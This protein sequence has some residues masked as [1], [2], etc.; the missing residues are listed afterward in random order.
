MHATYDFVGMTICKLCHML[1]SRGAQAP[2]SL[3]TRSF[4][5]TLLKRNTNMEWYFIGR[6]I[7]LQR[8][9]V[10][11]WE[12]TRNNITGSWVGSCI[13]W[14][15]L[16]DLTDVWH[17]LRPCHALEITS[18][19]SCSHYCNRHQV[20]SPTR[21]WFR[22]QSHRCK[23]RVHFVRFCAEQAKDILYSWWERRLLPC[24]HGTKKMGLCSN[25]VFAQKTQRKIEKV[26]V[27]W[28]DHFDNS[29]SASEGLRMI[30]LHVFEFRIAT[31]ILVF[32]TW[33]TL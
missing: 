24:L 6:P 23:F 29:V 2:K 7:R 12:G 25:A 19:I 1:Y 15:S 17:V 9:H 11:R 16:I 22:I 28:Q 32:K 30:L 5:P 20:S 18:Q 14:L 13:P 21:M 27:L 31:D 26:A 33:S 10:S 4:V 8:R 3:K